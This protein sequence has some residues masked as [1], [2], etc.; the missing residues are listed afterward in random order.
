MTA[1]SKLLSK[2]Q[3]QNFSESA[4]LSRMI[5]RIMPLLSENKRMAAAWTA[6]LTVG[7]GFA[8]AYIEGYESGKIKPGAKE[9]LLLGLV[10]GILAVVIWRLTFKAHPLPPILKSDAYYWQLVPAHV[11]FAIFVTVTYRLQ[12]QLLNAE[13]DKPDISGESV[14]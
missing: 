10:S 3:G 11:I 2:V 8:L 5:K 9:M 14:T 4:Q 7:L 6:H 12:Q 1:F 13:E